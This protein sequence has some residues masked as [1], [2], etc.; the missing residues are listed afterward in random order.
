MAATP[1]LPAALPSPARKHRGHHRRGVVARACARG[2]TVVVAARRTKY[3]VT[4]ASA[5]GTRGRLCTSPGCGGGAGRGWGVGPACAKPAGP[6]RFARHPAS[7]A[8]VSPEAASASRHQ[9][10]LC[11]TAALPGGGH[12]LYSEHA[13]PGVHSVSSPI[14]TSHFKGR[15]AFHTGQTTHRANHPTPQC[16]QTNAHTATQSSR[17]YSRGPGGLH[18]WRDSWL[19]SQSKPSYRPSPVVAQHDCTNDVWRDSDARPS[20]SDT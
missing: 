20:L 9:P 2:L 3:A 11:A 5:D 4:H 8:A 6:H 13:L 14:F 18:L 19:A 15:R 12:V 10:C 1:T 7:C 17:H 16:T